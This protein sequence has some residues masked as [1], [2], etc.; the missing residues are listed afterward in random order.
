MQSRGLY[1]PRTC[2]LRTAP[3]RW[4]RM[5]GSPSADS[6]AAHC[7]PA[8]SDSR[9]AAAVARTLDSLDPSSATDMAEVDRV[10]ARRLDSD[11][12][13]DPP[14]VADY[15]I[16]GGG[17]RLRPA[18]LLLCAP[19]MRLRGHASTHT[20]AAVVEIIHTAT[21]LHDDVV[22]ESDAAPRPRDRQRDFG[23]RRIGAGR[24]LPVL[25]RFQLM[26]GVE[27]HA[28]AGYPGR[29]DQ[30]DRRRRSA[31]ADEHAGDADARRSALPARDPSARRRK[32]FEAAA[33]LGRVLG[34]AP[35]DCEE[36]LRRATACTS[37]TAFQL[38]DDVLDY[39]ATPTQIGKN[40]GDDLAE[41]KMTLPLIRGDAVGTPR[42]SAHRSAT[43][44]TRRRTDRFRAGRGR[45]C[46]APARWTYAR[47][48]AAGRSAVR[49]RC[50]TRL[51]AIAGRRESAT[52]GGFR[53]AA[54]VLTLRA[55]SARS[56]RRRHIGV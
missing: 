44:S 7:V 42:A 45:R 34:E 16:G 50:A 35:T 6:I 48:R 25:A 33:R 46:I 36:A 12:R 22:D 39:R 26:V 40:L 27:S 31:A 18:L 21:L 9:V 53:G 11:V 28:R 32:L 17:K 38:V 8:S 41:G 2:V 23:N 29:R 52:I 1:V 54:H 30:R 51:P 3:D 55:P 20:L 15:I 43:P 5:A 24:R 4:A 37:G 10:L 14:S 13:A 19:R 49:R 56:S 47:E